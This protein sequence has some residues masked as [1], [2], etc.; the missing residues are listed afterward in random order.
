MPEEATTPIGDVQ[1]VQDR[2]QSTTV[3]VPPV[4]ATWY[5]NLPKFWQAFIQLG[6]AGLVALAFIAIGGFFLNTVSQDRAERRERDAEDRD[7]RR[8]EIAQADRRAESVNSELRAMRTS[9]EVIASDIRTSSVEMKANR[10]K[11]DSMMKELKELIDKATE[12]LK[13]KPMGAVIELFF[14]SSPEPAPMPREATVPAGL[15]SPSPDRRP[16]GRG[17]S[18]RPPPGAGR[19]WRPRTS[20]R[21]RAARGPADTTRRRPPP[22]PTP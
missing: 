21:R 5:T 22:G 18:R 11:L 20:P 3:V 12:V 1:V 2:R 10:Q 19:A 16:Q 14:P 4:Q 7:I 6:F 13:L 17:S 9:F 15:P 8:A